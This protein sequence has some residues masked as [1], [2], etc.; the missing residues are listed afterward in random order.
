[1]HQISE[2][3]FYLLLIY[4]FGLAHSYPAK[5]SLKNVSSLTFYNNKMTTCIRSQTVQQMICKNNCKYAPK[6][7]ICTNIGF[8]DDYVVW[9]CVG[10]NLPAGYRVTNSVIACEGYDYENDPDVVEGSCGIT[11]DLAYKG[12]NRLALVIILLPLVFVF[13]LMIGLLVA[14]CAY[15]CKCKCRKPQFFKRNGSSPYLMDYNY[16]D[17]TYNGTTKD[18]NTFKDSNNVTTTTTTNRPYSK[19]ITTTINRVYQTTSTSAHL[20]PTVHHA[21][22]SSSAH[23]ISSTYPSLSTH[24]NTSTHSY[25]HGTYASGYTGT[26]GHTGG[27]TGGYTGGYT[28]GYTHHSDSSNDTYHHTDYSGFHD[29]SISTHD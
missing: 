1:M 22:S 7:I 18:Y 29:V 20:P 19:D 27:H 12:I 6:S 21:S 9:D 17:A 5:I 14:L 23:P 10:D 28:S 13:I 26:G 4:L 15:H 11:Y 16:D 8:V 24:P 3:K 2:M 25:D